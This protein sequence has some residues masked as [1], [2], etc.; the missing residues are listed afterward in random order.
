MFLNKVR[1]KNQKHN[2]ELI[3]TTYYY[4]HIRGNGYCYH[5]ALYKYTTHNLIIEQGGAHLTDFI[6]KY[7]SNLF[8]FTFLFIEISVFNYFINGANYH[9]NLPYNY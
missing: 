7:L 2:N 9:S 1:L 6:C 8:D 5:N 4:S 3:Y